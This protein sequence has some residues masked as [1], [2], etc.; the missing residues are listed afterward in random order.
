MTGDG[1]LHGSDGSVYKGKFVDGQFHGEG[2]MEY[3]NGDVFQ[4]IYEYGLKA[5]EGSYLWESG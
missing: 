5:G 4:G 1:K 3:P 2:C